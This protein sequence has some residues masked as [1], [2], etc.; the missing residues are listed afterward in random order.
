MST[1]LGEQRV[2]EDVDGD[3]RA[4]PNFVHSWW[5]VVVSFEEILC[6]GAHACT[7]D[8]V[9]HTVRFHGGRYDEVRWQLDDDGN[10]T[11]RRAE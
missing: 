2:V 5:P 9:T 7:H 6:S 4:V 8:E 3:R 1:T 10:W 11:G